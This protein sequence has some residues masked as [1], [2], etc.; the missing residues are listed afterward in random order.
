MRGEKSDDILMYRDA[1][2]MFI[3]VLVFVFVIYMKIILM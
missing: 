1:Q 3:G 2:Y